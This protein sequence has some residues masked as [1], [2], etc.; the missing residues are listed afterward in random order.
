MT[1]APTGSVETLSVPVPM[2]GAAAKR[3][4]AAKPPAAVTRITTATAASKRF[5][6]LPDF[7]GD[8]SEEA[9]ERGA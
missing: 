7:C 3:Y 6:R 2:A 4:A 1:C 9:V 8:A 5:Q